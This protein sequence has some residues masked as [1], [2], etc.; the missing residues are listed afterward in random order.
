MDEAFEEAA[1][2]EETAEK[3]AEVPERAAGGNLYRE[4]YLFIFFQSNRKQ[5]WD[6]AY[7]LA[8]RLNLLVKAV[9][10]CVNDLNRPGVILEETDPA[11]FAGLIRSAD[12]VCTDSY[13]A[14]LL[15]ILFHK[16]MC[17]FDRYPVGDMSGRNIRIL[18]ILDAVGL[19]NRLYDDNTPLE[20]YLEKT[21]FIPVQYKLDA[22]RLKSKAFLTR[23]FGVA[24]EPGAE[25]Q[26][27]THH[28]REIFHLCVG[29]GACE[30]VCP[31]KAVHVRMQENGFLE[32]VV[33]ETDCVR[34]GKCTQVC[35]MN[36]ETGGKPLTEGKLLSYSDEDRSLLSASDAGGLARR[37]QGLCLEQGYAVAGCVF[38]Q[39]AMETRHL[40]VLPEGGYLEPDVQYE[41]PSEETLSETAEETGGEAAASEDTGISADG[42]L[43]ETEISG[44]DEYEAA[45]ENEPEEINTEDTKADGDGIHDETYISD[46]LTAEV[47]PEEEPES[48]PSGTGSLYPEKPEPER[49]AAQDQEETPVRAA[50]EAH[51]KTDTDGKLLFPASPEEL[52][53]AMQGIKLSQSNFSAVWKLLEKDEQ[54]VLLIGTPCQVAAARRVFEERTNIRYIDFVCGGVPT[55]LLFRK[56]RNTYRGK[57]GIRQEHFQIHFRYKKADRGNL[58]IRI[59][60]GE[61]EK[62]IPMKKDALCRMLETGSCCSEACYNC[63]WRDCSCADLRIGTADAS[64]TGEYVSQSVYLPTSGKHV[65]YLGAGSFG[66]RKEDIT[67]VFCMTDAGKELLDLLMTQGYWEGLHRQQKDLYLEAVRT[68]N[69]PFPVFYPELMEMLSDDNVSLRRILNEFAKP[70]EKSEKVRRRLKRYSVAGRKQEKLRRRQQLNRI[71]GENAND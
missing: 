58:Y 60:D 63:R 29:C 35:P 7:N 68:V 13:H 45:A 25:K 51:E 59:T 53:N 23:A 71:K 42:T 4:G 44:S 22:L 39:D 57:S 49:D 47:A 19:T 8:K 50:E 66:N 11:A 32:A 17:C 9:P 65:P 10:Y 64:A 69:N 33:S 20:Q 3:E 67:A 6:A 37:L 21:D 61:R 41:I 34:C 70:I 56:Y 16:E 31:E 2:D 55:E 40:V 38:D 24:P 52:L 27:I 30:A 54:P 36:S 26:E 5:Y 46:W 14:V 28:V 43:P 12:Y 1:P 48:E 18:Q 62:V 15:A